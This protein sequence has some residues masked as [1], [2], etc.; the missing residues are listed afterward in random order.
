MFR[1]GNPCTLYRP[2]VSLDAKRGVRPHGFP[3][4]KTLPFA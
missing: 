4:F 3:A 2:A 1:A